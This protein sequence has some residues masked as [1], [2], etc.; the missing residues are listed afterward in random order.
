MTPGSLEGSR[1]FLLLN[2]FHKC[3]C[4]V[5]VLRKIPEATCSF[6]FGITFSSNN[7]TTFKT[8]SSQHRAGIIRKQVGINHR[9]RGRAIPPCASLP[10]MTGHNSPS[11]SWPIPCC[12]ALSP[13]QTPLWTPTHKLIAVLHPESQCPLEPPRESHLGA[14]GQAARGLRGPSQPSIVA[15]CKIRHSGTVSHLG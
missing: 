7:E 11:L 12:F 10:Q 8:P 9:G 1:L 5:I 14:Y 2:R 15:N 4:S 6:L 13:P 3:I